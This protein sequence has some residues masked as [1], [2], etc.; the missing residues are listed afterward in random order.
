MYLTVS[1][2]IG[3]DYR[4]RHSCCTQFPV[5]V[6]L[7]IC[8]LPPPLSA[9]ESVALRL[10]IAVGLNFSVIEQLLAAATDEPQLLVSLKSP[11]LVPPKV[12]L[13]TLRAVVPTLVRV[14]VCAALVTPTLVPGKGT[15]AAD[16]LTWVPTPVRWMV[17]GLP[18]PLSAME[19]VAVRIPM[20]LGLKV[21]V[22]V[23]VFPAATEVPQLLLSRK[24]ALFV[25]PTV[26]PV[27]LKAVAPKFVKV[28]ELT[29]VVPSTTVGYVMLAVDSFTSDPVP[30]SA[31][32][33][34][35]PTALSVIITLPVRVPTA[36]GVKVTEIVH[37]APAITALPQ[38]L[39]SLKSPLAAILE[40][41]RVA[42]PV[43]V[44]VTTLAALVVLR[45]WVANVRLVLD[46]C[47]FGPAT[48]L[49]S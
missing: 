33:C 17:C 5:P 32:D 26:M 42:V 9:M 3:T 38:V 7:T 22:I 8:G 35:L 12:M 18:P 16:N 44:S 6:N 2:D 14:T 28:A 30:V 23:Q 47:T 31:I 27:M 1:R 41:F 4:M 45:S 39:V 19:T 34:G 49:F 46:N 15:V 43:F 40:M 20:A 36:V 29:L 25:P 11:G 13:V 21:R 37:L 10:P 24:S 48:T